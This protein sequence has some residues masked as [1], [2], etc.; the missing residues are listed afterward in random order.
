MNTITHLGM[1]RLPL[2]HSVEEFRNI[3]LK[4]IEQS[5]IHFS[6]KILISRIRQKVTFKKEL[7]EIYEGEIDF[8]GTDLDFINTI[9][10]EQIWDKKLMIDFTDNRQNLNPDIYF[11]KNSNLYR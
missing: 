11:L 1:K 6:F 9:I 10:W 8:L 2:T 7:N 3:V 5:E 4:E